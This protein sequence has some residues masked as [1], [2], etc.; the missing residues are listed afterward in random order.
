MTLDTTP[1]VAHTVVIE[2]GD[3]AGT[4]AAPYAISDENWQVYPSVIAFSW[5]GESFRFEGG[6][7]PDYEPALAQR[8]HGL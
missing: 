8:R 7:Y 5:S 6:L 1:S 3:Y 4:A 2:S